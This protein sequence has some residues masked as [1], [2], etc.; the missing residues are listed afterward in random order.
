MRWADLA[1]VTCNASDKRA[2]SLTV[3]F[4]RDLVR[5]EM[6][7]ETPGVEDLVRRAMG[8][9][10]MGVSIATLGAGCMAAGGRS[11]V[12]TLG[13]GYGTASCTWIS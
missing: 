6:G 10:G 11:N 5:L 12:T 4:P 13:A 9:G 2:C 1:G 7:A 3:T 8:S